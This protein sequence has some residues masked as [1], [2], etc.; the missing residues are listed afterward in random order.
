MLATDG[1]TAATRPMV[2]VVDQVADQPRKMQWLHLEDPQ[3][4]QVFR[5]FRFMATVAV[6][7]EIE[8][9][10][11]Q[12]VVAEVRGVQVEMS[13]QVLRLGIV[14]RAMAEQRFK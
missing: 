12:V 5:V 6:I 8:L 14:N 7:K 13:R 11:K 2:G 4:K 9:A 3:L 10:V 1:I